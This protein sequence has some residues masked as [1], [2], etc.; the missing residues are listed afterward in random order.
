[1]KKFYSFSARIARKQLA[2]VVGALALTFASH[3]SAEASRMFVVSE[4]SGLA[5]EVE[6]SLIDPTTLEVR[7]E[8][9]S[10]LVPVGFDNSDQLLT[11]VSWDFDPTNP[12]GEPTIVSGSVRIGPTSTSINFSSG[13]YGPNSDVSGEW[14]FG[15]AGTT[16]LSANFISTNTSHATPFGGANLDSTAN[17]SGPQAG[18]V[19]DP[20]LV[21][22]GGLGAIR[23]EIVATLTLS[24]PL[25]N[26][27]AIDDVIVEYGSDAAFAPGEE[28]HQIPE[29]SSGVI[30]ALCMLAT[31]GGM[32]V[33]RRRPTV[34]RFP[35]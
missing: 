32:L 6:F 15:N 3:Q 35:R 11:S 33:R 9:L 2:I 28:Q 5:A 22:L 21:S 8:N 31:A 19:A 18:L 25:A 4:P 20:E 34:A 16:G 29:P 27:D 24:G 13:I 14:G 23:R 17:L 7:V 30:V 1:V 26:V 10:S 12:P